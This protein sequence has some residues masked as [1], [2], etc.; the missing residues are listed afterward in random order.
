M[1]TAAAYI[2]VSDER[3]D[4]FSPDS[5]LK[6]IREYCQKND[7]EL[8]DELIFYDDGISA[9]STKKRKQ[10][11]DMIAL[12]KLKDKPFQMILVWK[13][14]RFARNQEESIVYKSLL[15]KNGVEVVSIS[16]PLSDNP[17]GGLIERIIEWMDEY[18][19]IRLSDEVRR[20][21]T[22]RA[23]RGLPNVAPP[24]GY[25]MVDGNYEIEEQEAAIVRTI[26][27]MFVDGTGTRKIS[28]YLQ[29]LG[30]K[31][32]YG[33][34]LDNRGVEYILYNPCYM[35]YLRWNPHGKSASKRHYNNP[36]DILQKGSHAPIV[37]EEIFKRAQQLLAER[38]KSRQKYMREDFQVSE[39]ALKGLVRCD[40]CGSTLVLNKQ[41]N[42]LQCH[43]YSR[44]TCSVS[45]FINLP[46]LNQMVIDALKEAVVKLSF[47]IATGDQKT[48]ASVPMDF[49]ALIHAEQLKLE[50]AKQAYQAGVDSLNEYKA[51]KNKIEHQIKKLQE[52]KAKNTAGQNRTD[53]K[54]FAQTVTNVIEILENKESS[55]ELKNKA[56]KSVLQKI[57][58]YKPERRIELFFYQ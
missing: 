18:Y 23:T 30:I 45:H 46:A 4:E 3:Q 43:K 17:F 31:N 19:L 35:G 27:E 37:S 11:N 13:F 9:K 49:D 36:D 14:S 56:L 53:L 29:S 28:T 12:A 39:F 32:K 2:R 48:S 42:G 55:E 51:A 40:T 54:K 1:K 22:E 8:P 10:F 5:Q 15:R 21:M 47:N 20:G 24:F 16:E 57:V 52:Q 7:I 25:R 50:R 26:F 44:G 41:N 58:F 6:L 38:K 34:P 33:N